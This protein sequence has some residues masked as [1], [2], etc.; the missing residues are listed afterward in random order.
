MTDDYPPENGMQD[1]EARLPR[2]LPL[3][4]RSETAL[5]SAAD[6][7]AAFLDDRPDLSLDDTVTTLA[8]GRERFEHRLAVVAGDP[9]AAV[10]ALREPGTGPANRRGA[11]PAAT[12]RTVLVFTGQG[13]QYTGMAAGAYR[14]YP[15]FRAWLDQADALLRD[16]LP[17]GLLDCMFR[18]ELADALA[19]TDVAAAAIVA[20]QLGLLRVLRRYGI[21]PDTVF[22]HSVGEFCAAAAAGAVSDEDALRLVARRGV[23]MAERTRPGAMLA[24]RSAADPADGWGADAVAALADETPDVC[25][26]VHN[27]PRDL[28]LSGDADAVAGLETRLEAAGLKCRRLRTSH[29]FHSGLLAPMADDFAAAAEL[30]T[31]SAPTGAQWI[32]CSHGV[33]T[34]APDASYWRDHLT[35]PVRFWDALTLACADDRATV[36]MEVGPHPALLP[37]AGR[38]PTPPALVPVLAR[39]QDAAAA[40]AG[41]AAEAWCHGAPADLTGGIPGRRRHLPGYGFNRRVHSV[42]PDPTQP[43]AAPAAPAAA[44]ALDPAGPALP[45]REALAAL[46]TD[47]LGVAPEPE[48]GF[49]QSGGDSLTLLRFQQRIQAR[50]G[51]APSLADLLDAGTFEA[52]ANL[53]PAA[54]AHPPAAAPAPAAE[55]AEPVTTYQASAVQQG[56]LMIDLM[57]PDS[58]QHNVTLAFEVPGRVDEAAMA[59]AFRDAQVRHSALRTVFTRDGGRFVPEIRPEP[60]AAL[61]VVE[62]G[63]ADRRPLVDDADVREWTREMSDPPVRC[64]GAATALRGTLVRGPQRSLVVLTAHH[65][66]CDA[67]SMGIL[68][69]ELAEDYRR[70]RAGLRGQAAPAPVQYHDVLAAGTDDSAGRAYWLEQLDGASDL[71]PVPTDRPRPK[72][73]EGS[74]AQWT[75]TLSAGQSAR[76]RELAARLDVTLFSTMLA[77]YAVL[78]RVRSGA[79]DLSIATPATGRTSERA[80]GVFGP[81]L[82]TLVL[83]ARITPG[84][85]FDALARDLQTTVLDAIRH[86]DFPFDRLVAAL[87]PRREPDRTPLF[88][89]MFTMP[90]QFALPDFDGRQARPVELPGLGAKYDLTLY[91]TP[92]ADGRLRLD[93]EYDPALFDESTVRGLADDY[94]ALLAALAAAPEAAIPEPGGPVGDRPAGD[95]QPEGEEAG[96]TAMT[97]TER[98]VAGLWSETLGVDIA[99][100]AD[101]FFDAG[102]HSMLVLACLAEIQDRF[103]EAT[104]QDFFAHRTVGAFAAHL[105][106]LAGGGTAAEPEAAPAE[107]EPEKEPEP[108]ARSTAATAE[109]VTAERVT[110]SSSAGSPA[111]RGD[112]LLTG[113]AGYLGAHLLATLLREPGGAVV[114]PVRP[115]D[116]VGGT[117]R[118]EEAV[119]RYAPDVLPQVPGR[120]TVVEVD[121]RELTAQTLGTSI[122]GIGT[123]VHSAAESKMFGRIEDLRAANVAPTRLLAELALAH[124]WRMAHVST[125]SAVGAAPGDGRAVTVREEDFD[126]GENFDNPYSRS[127]FEAEQVIHAAVKNGLD[128]TV[129]RVGGLIGDSTSGTF[130]PDPRANLLY[131]LVR[132]IMRCGLVPDAPGFTMNV[133]P[134]DF[135]AA[136]VLRLSDNASHSGRT[137]H[138]LNPEQLTMPALTGILR[139]LGYPA[140]LTD[141]QSVADWLTREGA[142]EADAEA[143]PFLRQFT[144]PAGTVVSHDTRM[145]TAAL[146]GLKCPA[147]DLALLRV[148]IGHCVETGFFPKSRLWDFV[149]RSTVPTSA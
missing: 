103:P 139:D 126:R 15:E 34:Q 55:P 112:V 73:R 143:A 9:A 133:T 2:V 122:A 53:L 24:V 116:G 61:E 13:S 69:D 138:V 11:A 20:V 91:V 50:L 22:G 117:T 58:N 90:D 21:T 3:S 148:V 31:W 75:W 18:P 6:A 88:S 115:R 97:E 51:T 83:R 57:Q 123:V 47:L 32:S 129:H 7:L 86:S 42:R 40:V 108:A 5:R 99:G 8:H 79:D 17:T 96:E 82:N 119:A 29:A 78:L 72:V 113:A 124:G 43:A 4:A 110:A 84:Q 16:E 130:L 1:D 63:V 107:T 39:D 147:P 87:N 48:T 71:V 98:Y 134:V 144:A 49:L 38:L 41:A 101:D 59:A 45:P 89:V 102:G 35:E 67:T 77:T 44:A 106:R 111:G 76:A 60:G 65:A 19:R 68:V 95:P 37:L 54:A 100:A 80:Q 14:A 46:W 142:D 70:H 137:F 131:Q 125:A 64:L 10:R 62:A 28:V 36:L 114:C 74:G 26:A 149:S 104:I 56:M 23:L 25:V 81:F 27:S 145:T 94:D 140:I 127:K 12:P 92:A 141:P 136:A 128:A 118:L 135:A 105:D 121:L 52:M 33:M 146:A 120:V 66:V 93:L 109:R 132:A 30:V 85:G